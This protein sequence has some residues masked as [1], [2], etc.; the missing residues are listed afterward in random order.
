MLGPAHDPAL[1]WASPGWYVTRDRPSTPGRSRRA[2]LV[3]PTHASIAHSLRRLSRDAD[4]WVAG[5]VGRNPAVRAYGLK[6]ASAQ[7]V[8]MIAGPRHPCASA[9][10]VK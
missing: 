10:L 6:R 2:Q 1:V 9:A 5:G 3:R 7:I 8:R 4:S